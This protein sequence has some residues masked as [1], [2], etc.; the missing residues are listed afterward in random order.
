[1]SAILIAGLTWLANNT[2]PPTGRT[3]APFDGHCNDCHTG[4]SNNY[5]GTISID[6]LPGTIDPNTT[7]P[8]QITLTPTAGS[9][10]RGGFQ[11]VVVDG[12]DNDTGDLANSNAQ[13]GTEMFAAR[14]YLEQ[15]GAKNFSGG[16][17]VSWSFT[18]QS[19]ASVA[20]NT[21]KFYY[22]GNFCNG[23][24]SSGSIINPFTE[25]SA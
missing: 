18:W 15:R 2:N 19:P 21:V 9:P 3:G 20:G 7:Y 4:N 1:V 16:N 25:G 17:P 10:V 6:G 8:L 5:N 12:N 24:N 13:S 11:L 23:N 22:I 14:E